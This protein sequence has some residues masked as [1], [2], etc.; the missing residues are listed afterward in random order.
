MTARHVLI[1]YI[2]NL[3]LSIS[4]DTYD[5]FFDTVKKLIMSV[6]TYAT[7]PFFVI[8]RYTNFV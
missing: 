3:Y 4:T 6:S 7:V 8:I 5:Q 2:N 1:S